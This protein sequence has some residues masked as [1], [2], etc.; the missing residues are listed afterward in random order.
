M[1]QIAQ[2]L[3]PELLFAF[4]LVLTRLGGV[5]LMLPGFGEV[6]ISPRIRICLAVLVSFTMFPLVRDGLPPLPPDVYGLVMLVAHEAL[7]GLFIGVFSR[8]VLSCL[9]V[10]GMIIS[11]QMGIS[12]AVMFNPVLATQGSL[13]SVFLTLAG[14][15]MMFLTDLHHLFF[16]AMQDSYQIFPATGALPLEDM[17]QTFSQIVS[18]SFKIAVQLSA[19]FLVLGVVFFVGMGLLARLMPQMQVFFI[20]MPLQILLGLLLVSIS[21][22]AMLILYLDFFNESLTPFLVPR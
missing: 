19:P 17:S 11:T 10:G 7:I 16:H 13:I 21:F 4:L 1:P 6:F 9:E 5:F 14:I 20:A 12:A 15:E 2:L 3:V 22:S 8:I 18:K